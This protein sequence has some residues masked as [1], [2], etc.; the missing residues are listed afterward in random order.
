MLKILENSSLKSYN[1]F[2]ID[3]KARYFVEVTSVEDLE[4]I[5]KM[6]EFKTVQ[7][8][9]LGEG[10]NVLLMKDFDG[11]VIKMSLGGVGVLEEDY[12]TALVKAM[13]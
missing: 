3:A 1:T 13:A 12:E 11:L 10:S 7:K 6:P 4:K 9:V 5:L 8:L 2:H